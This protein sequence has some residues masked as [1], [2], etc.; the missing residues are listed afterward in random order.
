MAASAGASGSLHDESDRHSDCESAKSSCSCVSSPGSCSL[1]ESDPDEPLPNDWTRAYDSEGHVY[2]WHRGTRQ[3]QWKR[4]SASTPLIRQ[5]TSTSGQVRSN[6]STVSAAKDR[7]MAQ[8]GVGRPRSRELPKSDGESSAG[9]TRRLGESD[10]PRRIA[11]QSTPGQSAVAHESE[12]GSVAGSAER[13]AGKSEAK[14]R[15]DQFRT[16]L[17]EC[18]VQSLM[19]YRREDCRHGRIVSTEDFKHLARK[20]THS[21][22][23]K[24]AG[25]VKKE[26]LEFS[27]ALRGKTK[28][29][30]KNFMK[31]Y[32]G[33]YERT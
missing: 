33:A 13:H 3:R 11:S 1:C 15:F 21:I 25:G 16:E 14:R 19:P 23:D 2:Y 24:Y 4:P 22:I 8:P 17:S 12:S 20:L 32:K 18:V 27:E 31:R 28:E 9:P 7:T 6:S 29:T 26:Q 10:H 5:R 30:V